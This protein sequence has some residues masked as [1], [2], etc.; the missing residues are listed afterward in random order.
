MI[1]VAI[2]SHAV[3]TPA[4]TVAGHVRRRTIQQ[5]RRY[6]VQQQSRHQFTPHT[7]SIPWKPSISCKG[8]SFP[9]SSSMTLA[10]HVSQPSHSA[11][12]ASECRSQLAQVLPFFSPPSTAASN[13]ASTADEVWYHR[14]QT[15]LQTDANA[16]PIPIISFAGQKESNHTLLSLLLEDG[17]VDHT[18]Q[19]PSKLAEI[20]Q[21]NSELIV[22]YGST[23]EYD[24]EQRVFHAPLPWLRDAGVQFK[25]CPASSD[26]PTST[27]DNIYTS[28]KAI[29]TVSYDSLFNLSSASGAS[30]ELSQLAEVLRTFSS[31]SGLTLVVSHKGQVRNAVEEEET[32]IRIAQWAI[33]KGDTLG[34]AFKIQFVDLDKAKEAQ[35]ALKRAMGFTTTGDSA[36]LD[37]S[38]QWSLFQSLSAQSGLPRL[39]QGVTHSIGDEE[40]HLKLLLD[41]A[42]EEVT[43]R[44]LEAQSGVH[45]LESQ[46]TY[47]STNHDHESTSLVTRIMDTVSPSIMSSE[48]STSL[49]SPL[50]L[51]PEWYNIP[52]IGDAE[53]RMRVQEKLQDS[54][55]GGNVVE[56]R[57]VWWCG[58]LEQVQREEVK[59]LEKLIA[60]LDK[61][62]TPQSLLLQLRLLSPDYNAGKPSTSH[63]NLNSEPTLLSSPI[64]TARDEFFR[65]QSSK[66]ASAGNVSILDTLQRRLQSIIYKFYT[67]LGLTTIATTYGLSH[68]LLFTPESIPLHMTSSTSFA[69]LLFG[70]VY[71]FYSLQKSHSKLTNKLLNRDILKRIP[72]NTNHQVHTLVDDVVKKQVLGWKVHSADILKAFAQGKNEQLQ[73]ELRQWAAVRAQRKD[74]S[75]SIVHGKEVGAGDSVQV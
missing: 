38:E 28:P 73:R 24:P 66:E 37:K 52:F 17:L 75:Q 3:R 35:V 57:L 22:R 1:R 44:F 62:K 42:T 69:V 8:V 60:D 13:Q 61:Q 67:K 29:L 59:K 32:A 11:A 4:R 45:S 55:L 23:L 34:S 33:N 47:L 71:S 50:K 74:T 58:K 18:G 26:S 9:K 72:S 48:N 31:H 20:A 19:I 41:H 40:D 64:T 25:Q 53:A 49:E 21:N 65:R 63:H 36:Q 16:A 70:S 27:L 46:A 10:T 6:G 43:S 51:I 39:I 54:W 14:V 56:S 30:S 2:P 68:E 5:I 12:L 15:A 7:S